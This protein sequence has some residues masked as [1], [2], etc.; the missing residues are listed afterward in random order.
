MDKSSEAVLKKI[1]DLLNSQS[2]VSISSP[3]YGKEQIDN[4]VN[5]GYIEKLDASTLTC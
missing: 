1:Y 5:N 4:L 3:E 2:E